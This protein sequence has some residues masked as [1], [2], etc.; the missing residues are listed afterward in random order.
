MRD[1]FFVRLHG[2]DAEAASGA[3]PPPDLRAECARAAQHIPA[4]RKLAN[5]S[6]AVLL[7]FFR[8]RGGLQRAWQLAQR[9]RLHVGKDVASG[10][11]DDRAHRGRQPEVAMDQRFD[12]IG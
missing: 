9:S 1:R 3:M 7:Q 10:L 4:T 11:R 12:V 6:L 2:D 5:H 8:A